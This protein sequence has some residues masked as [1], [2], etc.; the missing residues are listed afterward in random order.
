MVCSL[1]GLVKWV[2]VVELVPLVRLVETPA[3]EDVVHCP[4]FQPSQPILA[5]DAGAQCQGDEG[6]PCFHAQLRKLA[7]E[8]LNGYIL[9]E[10]KGST[11]VRGSFAW[12]DL[13]E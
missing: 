1:V 8:G 5:G 7:A 11:S 10:T 13:W 2:V 12:N 4:N 3:L 6:R 9:R